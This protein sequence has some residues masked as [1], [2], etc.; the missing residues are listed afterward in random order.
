MPEGEDLVSLARHHCTL[1]IFLSITLL[2]TIQRD[3]REAGW[4]EDSPILVVHKA[5]W[6]GEEKIVRATLATVRDACRAAKIVT[7]SM[8]IASP[9]VGAR[10][11]ETLVRS[12]L[13]DASFTHRFRRAVKPGAS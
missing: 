9:T 10:Q 4:P 3:L 5:S 12:R 6:P 8:I 7:Q 1:C 2:S 13:Y 11:W